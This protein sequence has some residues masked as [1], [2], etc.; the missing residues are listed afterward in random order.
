MKMRCQRDDEIENPARVVNAM[1]YVKA[2]GK[3][4]PFT[5]L[6]DRSSELKV[7]PRTKILDIGPPELLKPLFFHPGQSTWRNVDPFYLASL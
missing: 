6:Y 5:F 7:S 2:K 3:K 4:F 1:C